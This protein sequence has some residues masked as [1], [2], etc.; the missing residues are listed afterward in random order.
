MTKEYIKEC[1][2]Q[3][4]FLKKKLGKKELTEICKQYFAKEDTK[5]SIKELIHGIYE[6]PKG[7]AT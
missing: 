3:R 6:L 7:K 4:W 5:Q 1:K 2:R